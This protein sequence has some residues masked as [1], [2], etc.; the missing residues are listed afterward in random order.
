MIRN[1]GSI[2][3]F[4]KYSITGSLGFILDM[5]TL[6]GLKEVIGVSALVAVVINQPLLLAFNFT[7]NKF[8]SF[9]N[10][11]ETRQ[12]LIRYGILVL[13]NY[14]VAVNL[15]YLFHTILDFDYRLVRIGSIL[16]SVSWNFLLYKF[17]VYKA[18][19]FG[20]SD[21]GRDTRDENV[22]KKSSL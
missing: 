12:Q 1:N 7:L 20:W 21:K 19:T 16:L 15:M 5:L 10:T 13:G 18:P 22:S 6:Y 14:V 11:H 3:Q 8:W 9:S 17:W 2:R 4:L